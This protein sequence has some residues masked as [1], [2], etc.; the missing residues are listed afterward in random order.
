MSI[1]N[2]PLAIIPARGGSKRFPGK[3]VAILAGKPL[4]AYAI[5]AAQ[6]SE[7]FDLVCVSSEDDEILRIAKKWGAQT[8]MKRPVELA[9]DLTP[10]KEVCAYLLESFS[11][12]GRN[13]GEF[14]LLLATNPLRTAADLREAY[15]LFKKENAV[16]C[17]SLVP[18]S[19]PPQRAVRV[20]AESGLVQP[21]FGTERMTQSQLLEPLYR[22]DGSIIFAQ[23]E[24]FLKTREFYGP[25]VVPYFIPCE[26]SVDIDSPLDLA[27]A[28]FLLKRSGLL[29]GD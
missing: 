21:Y 25:G 22:H 18:F 2:K 17:M 9:D 8:V 12:Q 11:S 24:M 26:R 10:L 1:P 16:T 27:W 28:E 5:E 19:H 3:N 15:Q 13:Y 7:V 6:E 14:G 20:D 29:E 4:I 23:S